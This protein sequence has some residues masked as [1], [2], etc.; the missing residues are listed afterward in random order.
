MKKKRLTNLLC[1]LALTVTGCQST[2]TSNT[3]LTEE[4]AN[5]EAQ[6]TLQ[7]DLI[8]ANGSFIN[9]RTIDVEGHIVYVPMD[10]WTSGFFPG[11]MWLDYD[12]TGN[13]KWKRLAEKYTKSLD[14]VKYLKWHH[15]VG[16]MIGC[17]YLTGYRLCHQPAYK[18]VIIEAAKSLST[19]FRPVAGVIQSWNTDRGWQSQRGWECPVII[20]NMMNL[21]L[22]FEATR[23]SGDSTF[24]HIAVSHAD[25]TMK[26]H[27]R[28]DNSCYHVVDYSLED[29][30]VRKRQTAQG[31][32]DESS[33]ARGQAWAIY[34]YTV[35]YRYTHHPLYLQQAE[36]TLGFILN[37]QNMPQDLVPYWDFAAPDIPVA[38]RDASAA[39]CTA[40]AL[41]EMDGYCPGKGYKELA[42]KMVYSL[43]TPAY[44]AE[45]GRNGNFILMHSVGSIPHGA[46]IDV[47]LNYAD[48]YY[49]EALIRKRDLENNQP[50]PFEK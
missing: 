41:Y 43:S 38:P 36:N 14:S 40:S 44:K 29:G 28:A 50:L 3:F 39:A 18:D 4:I 10:D 15:D 1:L 6:H 30:T 37:H 7:T 45:Q 22:L 32:A 5:I 27:F 23:L 26:N 20:D 34:G 33:W 19:R 48:Y 13:E 25:A 47:P 46:E 49:Q 9:P 17:S 31:Y 16:F 8:E 2:Q 21:E 24:H 35:C 42:D 11:S 12:L